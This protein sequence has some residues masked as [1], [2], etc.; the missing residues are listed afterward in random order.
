MTTLPRPQKPNDPPIFYGL[1]AELLEV[2]M[3]AV[4]IDGGFDITEVDTS[5]DPVMYVVAVEDFITGVVVGDR[6]TAVRGLL[7]P[8]ATFWDTPVDG[9]TLPQAVDVRAR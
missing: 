2:G 3:T 7:V 6:R 9:S 1:P 5:G 4:T 8:L